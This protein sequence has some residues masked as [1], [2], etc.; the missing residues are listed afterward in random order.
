MYIIL[1]CFASCAR[2]KS[3]GPCGSND[4]QMLHGVGENLTVISTNAVRKQ[5]VSA[6]DRSGFPIVIWSDC[7]A[8]VDTA[9]GGGRRRR[10]RVDGV[11]NG[12]EGGRGKI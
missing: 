11:E 3:S 5:A 1:F 8:D 6:H 7:D 2:G 4:M 9:V 12:E 10:R